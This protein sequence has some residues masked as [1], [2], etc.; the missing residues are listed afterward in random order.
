MKTRTIVI[1]FSL[2]VL[3]HSESN[4]DTDAETERVRDNRH[5]IESR[6][7]RSDLREKLRMTRR[8]KWN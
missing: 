6:E 7:K 3:R 4:L 1:L 2:Y 5:E 8:P